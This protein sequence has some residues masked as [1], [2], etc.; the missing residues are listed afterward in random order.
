MPPPPV[1]KLL[2]RL[3]K[4]PTKEGKKIGMKIKLVEQSRT[5]T[6]PCSLGLT[7]LAVSTWGVTLQRT[8]NRANHLQQG[9]NYMGECMDCVGQY[10]ARIPADP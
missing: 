10:K 9:T 8:G 7:S 5:L 1:G 4:I 6:R 3:K 2:T